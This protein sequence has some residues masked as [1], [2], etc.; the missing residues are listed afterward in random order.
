MQESSIH[1]GDGNASPPVPVVPVLLSCS[2]EIYSQVM[3]ITFLV[4]PLAIF[5]RPAP[6]RRPNMRACVAPSRI[7]RSYGTVVAQRPPA[8]KEVKV[9]L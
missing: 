9:F 2:T 5:Q 4:Q 1:G 8:V 6:Y 3:K 7:H